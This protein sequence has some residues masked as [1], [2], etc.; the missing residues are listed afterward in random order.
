MIGVPSS[1]NIFERAM[2]LRGFEPLLLD[3][4]ANKPF[5]HALFRRLMEINLGVY[6]DF[7]RIAGPYLDGIRVA[8]DLGGTQA[9]MI[10][11]K[12]Y[13]ELLKPYHR[14]WFGSSS[15]ARKPRSSFTATGGCTVPAGPDRSRD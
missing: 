8:D 9:P 2:L 1:L 5:I 15:R 6:D 13:R 7:L 11:P 12:M 14:E 4:A 10:S 3:F